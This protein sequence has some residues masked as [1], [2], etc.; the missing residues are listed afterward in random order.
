M[1]P[2]NLRNARR[3]A[4]DDQALTTGGKLKASFI[5]N[6]H[7][8]E[9]FAAIPA[10]LDEFLPIIKKNMSTDDASQRLSWTYLYYHSKICRATAE[11]FRLGSENRLEEAKARLE[12]FEIELSEMEPSIHNAFDLFLYI[13]FLRER[14]GIKMTKYF[15]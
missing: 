8:A 4:V 12:V 1:C 5:N 3:L 13:K 14:F 9:K 6:P 7:T 15:Q 10:I 11:I 2:S